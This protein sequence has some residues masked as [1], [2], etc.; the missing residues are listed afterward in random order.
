MDIICRDENLEMLQNDLEKIGQ[1]HLGYCSVAYIQA[2]KALYSCCVRKTRHPEYKAIIRNYTHHFK[3]MKDLGYA[4]ETVK[5]SSENYLRSY[6]LKVFNL[7]AYDKL[8]F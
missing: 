8:T 6:T 4:S 5:E 1:G 2:C 7:G 3:I